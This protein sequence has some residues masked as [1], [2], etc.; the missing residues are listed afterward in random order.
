M[1]FVNYLLIAVQV[2]FGYNLIAPA[3]FY[4]LY[5]IS[6]KKITWVRKDNFGIDYAIIVTAYEQIHTIPFVISSILE[7]NYVNYIVYVVADKCDITTLIFE[8]PRVVIL[9][10]PVTLGSN[11][12][13]HKYAIDNFVREHDMV[14]IIDSDNLVDARYLI[15]LNKYVENGSL[16]VQGVRKAKNLNTNIARLDAARDIFY[17]FYD[18]KVLYQIGSSA[19]LSGS[20]MAFRLPFYRAFLNENQIVGAGFDKVLQAWVVKS[21][22]RIAFSDKALIYDEKTS[23]SDQLV[24]QRSRWINTWFKYFSLGFHLIG[25]GVKNLSRNQFLFGLVLLRPPLF[26]FL[27]ISFFALS[28]N[29][30]LGN[31]IFLVLWTLG[32]FLFGIFFLISLII[33]NADKS[34]YTSL[35]GAP[36][37]IFFQLLSLLKVRK[38]NSISVATKHDVFQDDKFNSK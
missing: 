25:L 19:T 1:E 16:A 24:K 13:S 21:N 3:I 10:P 18:G 9:K 15:E 30:L 11:T 32:F 17:H 5:L 20:G 34:I 31:I 23:K 2:V 4:L 26:I 38:A 37:F 12:K 14:T 7:L 35:I 22:H 36:K 8:D 6:P 33:S 28:V 27:I 29:L